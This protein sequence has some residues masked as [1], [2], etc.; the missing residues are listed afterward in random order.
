MFSIISF[1]KKIGFSQWSSHFLA[2]KIV[3]HVNFTWALSVVELG[4]GKWMITREILKKIPKEA[5]LSLFEI[6]ED[7][8]SLLRKEFQDY[9]N[10]S[11]YN[12]SAA[13]LDDIFPDG[14]VDIIISTLPL[15]SISHDW[16][17]SI[18][19]SIKKAL[20]NQWQFIQ[21]QYALQNLSSVKRYF[22]LRNISF[23]IRNLWPAFIYITEKSKNQ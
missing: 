5:T 7:S 20:K 11:I 15:G 17:E 13:H 22:S 4:A 9:K 12:K 10:V 23:E 18:L 14:S 2:K 6:S 19:I 21:Y 16:V 3:S 1:F 8:V